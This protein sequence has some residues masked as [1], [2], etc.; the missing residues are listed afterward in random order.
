MSMYVNILKKYK[1]ILICS[2]LT[3]VMHNIPNHSRKLLTES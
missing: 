1:M 3:I 2:I